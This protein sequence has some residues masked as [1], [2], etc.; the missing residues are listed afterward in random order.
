M[1]KLID[2]IFLRRSLIVFTV[3]VLSSIVFYFGG[4]KFKQLAQDDF[5]AAKSAL[6]SSHSALNKQSKEIALVDK[7]LTEFKA[8]SNSGFIG[9]ERRLSWVE[10][11]KEANKTIKLPVFKYSIKPQE[12][13]ERPGIKASKTVKSLSSPMILNLGL[14]HEGDLFKVIQLIEDNVQSR[15]VIDSCKLQSKKVDTLNINKENI[16][17]RCVLRWVNLKVKTNK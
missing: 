1:F 13:Y 8:L 16:S 2:F 11:M 10:S 6:N 7:Y 14:L 12:Q 5:N 17:A 9:E 15:F 3:L 4:V